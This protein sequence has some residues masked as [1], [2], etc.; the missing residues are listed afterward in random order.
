MSPVLSPELSPSLSQGNTAPRKFV[1]NLYEIT[2]PS[3]QLLEKDVI[4]IW[5][6]QQE[7]CVRLTHKEASQGKSSAEILRS[8]QQNEII[9]G[10]IKVMSLCR[11]PSKM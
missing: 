9:S 2:A 1:P 4:W 3:R 6:D 7:E 10:H 8:K 11:S 5:S